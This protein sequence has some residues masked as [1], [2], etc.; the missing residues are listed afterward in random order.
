MEERRKVILREMEAELKAAEEQRTKHC[1]NHA[2]TVR[3]IDQLKSGKHTHT[4]THTHTRT[5]VNPS[6]SPL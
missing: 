1:R 4:H 6:T 3:V 5:C 2:T